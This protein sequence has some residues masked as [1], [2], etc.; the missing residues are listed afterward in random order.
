MSIL[1]KTFAINQ[2]SSFVNV[3]KRQVY[4][5][6][7]WRQIKVGNNK[8]ANWNHDVEALQRVPPKPP[9]DSQYVVDLMYVINKTT[10]MPGMKTFRDWSRKACSTIFLLSTERIDV[11]GDR[12]NKVP[13][14]KQ[15]TW[16]ARSALKHTNRICC[17]K[18]DY[19]GNRASLWHE[20]FSN[21]FLLS[22]NKRR[23][24]LLVGDDLIRN[25][26]G[27]KIITASEM[28]EDPTDIRS[29]KLTIS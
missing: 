16:K 29:N 28:F 19:S 5:Y 23:S 10:I 27:N 13:S 18:A 2:A 8:H 22:A 26:L 21:F 6:E 3:Q 12:Y 24:Q 14:T 20:P 11:F 15:N 25:T 9:S 4:E 7:N 1:K 17:R